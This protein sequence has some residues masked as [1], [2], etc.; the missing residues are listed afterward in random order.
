MAMKVA[1]YARRSKPPR[2]WNLAEHPGEEAPG[3]IDA[4]MRRLQAWAATNSHEVVMAETDTASGRNPNRPGWQRVLG[5]VRG[6][7]VQC[8]ALTKTSRAMRNAKHYLETVEVFLQRG[9]WLEVL[10]QPIASVRGKDDPMAK[11]FRTVAAAF[12]EL[13]LDLIREQSLE[14]LEV[15]EDGRTYGPR[16][17]RPAGRPVKYGE[18]HRFRVR[19]GRRRHDRARCPACRMV[20]IGGDAAGVRQ[21]VSGLTDGKEEVAA[22]PDDGEPTGAR[23]LSPRAEA[24]LN[25]EEGA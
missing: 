20:E 15:R 19:N 12:N 4:Q 17:E 3:S 1:L 23:P 9:C 8:V 21:Q 13:E 16:S 7:H 14:V 24:R 22:Y 5:A 2:D 11:A 18:G 10:D 25:L 6:G